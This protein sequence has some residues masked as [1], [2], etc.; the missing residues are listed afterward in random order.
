MKKITNEQKKAFIETNIN[1]VP[2]KRIEAFKLLDI[3]EQY[4]KVREYVRKQNQKE[5]PKQRTICDYIT[6]Y[7]KSQSAKIDV[8]ERLIAK[9]QKWIDET[10]IRKTKEIEEQIAKL[11]AELEKYNRNSPTNP[12]II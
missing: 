7:L 10:S 6:A 11:Q 5:N 1:V 8:V 9:C 4:K 2:E 12:N 3:D